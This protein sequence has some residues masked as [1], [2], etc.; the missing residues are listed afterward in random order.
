MKSGKLRIEERQQIHRNKGLGYSL[1]RIAKI[2]GRAPSTILRELVRNAFSYDQED[3]SHTKARKSQEVVTS[4]RSEA[5]KRKMRLKSEEI[6]S[7]VEK[8]LKEGWG[9]IA[10]AGRVALEFPGYSLSPEAIYQWLLTERPELRQY[11]PVA[12]KARNRRIPG[13]KRRFRA[14]SAPK[15]SIEERPEEANQRTEIG[16]LEYDTIHSRRPG[17][18]AVLTTV[19]RKSRKTFLDKLSSLGSEECSNVLIVRIEK[20]VP[21]EHRHSMTS[22][23]GSENADFEK[24]DKALGTKSYFCHPHCAPERGTVENRNRFVRKFFPKGT[25]FGDIPDEYLKWLEDYINN[26]PLKCLGFKTPHEVWDEELRL[27]KAA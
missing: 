21:P 1:R 10:I 13:K 27:K 25:D 24:V 12:G 19:D 3:D 8:K 15:T 11:L 23:N 4:R 9:V 6:Q 22:D 16:H 2:L 7:F 14:P 17:R 5:S 26:Y 20:E 18:S